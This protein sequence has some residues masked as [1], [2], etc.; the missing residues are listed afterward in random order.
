MK[1]HKGRMRWASAVDGTEVAIG[2][3]IDDPWGVLSTPDGAHVRE[4]W[5]RTG[6]WYSTTW[7]SVDGVGYQRTFNAWSGEWT[8]S[9]PKRLGETPHGE[10]A[11]SVGGG[12]VTQRMRLVRALALAWVEPPVAQGVVAVHFGAGYPSAENVGWLPRRWRPYAVL[13]PPLGVL[14]QLGNLGLGGSL[15][16][17]VGQSV[18]RLR[19]HRPARTLAHLARDAHVWHRLRVRVGVL[20]AVLRCE[21]EHREV[22]VAGDEAR[23]VVT[24]PLD[25]ERRSHLLHHGL[26]HVRVDEL[27]EWRGAAARYMV[28]VGPHDI[29]TKRVV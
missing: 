26:H 13:P 23:Q 29:P 16:D 2:E 7:I 10:L 15:G 25:R 4:V 28:I 14:G 1:R 27:G 3:M 20:A 21:D 17:E 24:Q 18:A 19:H 22:D 8:F 6:P 11:L 9:G 5:T 12:T